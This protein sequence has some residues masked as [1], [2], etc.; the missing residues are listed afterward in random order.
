[1]REDEDGEVTSVFRV[2]PGLK[3]RGLGRAWPG[4]GRGEPQ[5]RPNYRA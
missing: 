2:G 3:A 1:M 5:A 4:L